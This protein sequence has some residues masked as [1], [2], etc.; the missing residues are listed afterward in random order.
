MNEN[1]AA[2]SAP[3]WTELTEAVARFYRGRKVVLLGRDVPQYRLRVQALAAMGSQPPFIVGN[4]IGRGDIPS[5]V[6]GYC[7]AELGTVTFTDT[8]RATDRL[9]AAPPAHVREALVR[10]TRTAPP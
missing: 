7:T 8:A 2:G 10:T 3:A 6:A 4:G 5:G 1:A 9:L